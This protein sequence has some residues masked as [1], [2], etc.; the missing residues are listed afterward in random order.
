VSLTK[1]VKSQRRQWQGPNTPSGD[2]TEKKNL[3]E[4]RLSRTNSVW[5]WFWQHYRS[6]VRFDWNISEYLSSSVWL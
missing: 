6:E 3:W 1:Q 2:K 4:T 5:L